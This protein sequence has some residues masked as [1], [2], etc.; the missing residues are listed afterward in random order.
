MWGPT[1]RLFPALAGWLESPLSPPPPPRPSKRQLHV[2]RHRAS[3][4]EA[5][6]RCQEA[7]G[8]RL[9][10]HVHACPA[11]LPSSRGPAEGQRPAPHGGRGQDVRVQPLPAGSRSRSLSCF[12][13]PRR[14]PEPDRL[15][16]GQLRLITSA[17][18]LF[19]RLA[20]R[21]ADLDREPL[22]HAHTRQ[23]G[24]SNLGGD[25]EQAKG[26]P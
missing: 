26:E 1:R 2:Q 15:Q 4:V 19:P 10:L 18:P 8:A 21:E 6:S 5:G 14:T 20:W 17:P 24:S 9:G 11:A 16:E 3:K 23:V 7:A 25:C 12:L 22:S 13:L